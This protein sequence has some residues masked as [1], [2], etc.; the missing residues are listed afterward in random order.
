MKPAPAP[1]RNRCNRINCGHRGFAMIEALI[2]LLIFTLAT[3]GLVGLQASMM[4]ANTGAKFRADAA[5]LASDLVGT[6]WADSPNLQS[7]TTANCAS[8]ANCQAWASRLAARLPGASYTIA[9][10]ASGRVE[11]SI[12]W[13]VPSEGSHAFSTVTSIN[14][15]S[16]S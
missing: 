1:Q 5:Y 16:I 6:M 10:Q 3:L 11:I 8:H 13:S 12:S 7:Y 4:R 2:A 15:N 14:A 9:P